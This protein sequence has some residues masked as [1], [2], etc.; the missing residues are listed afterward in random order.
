MACVYL[1][2]KLNNTL[3]C[4]KHNVAVDI[5]QCMGCKDLEYKK[6]KLTLPKKATFRLIEKQK[7]R[8]SIIYR[9][10]TKCA[11]C[12][13]KHAIELNEVYEGA[14]RGASMVNGFVIPMCREHHR[15]FHSNRAFALKYKKMFQQEYE[16]NHTR[17]DFINLIHKSYL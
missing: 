5:L 15:Q 9:D 8:F 17:D 12:G 7:N 3:W 11:I 14:R 2:Q 16:K 13:S 6:V 1:K 10:L 4:K